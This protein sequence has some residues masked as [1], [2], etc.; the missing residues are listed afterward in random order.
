MGVLLNIGAYVL[1][2]A[3]ERMTLSGQGNV[4]IPIGGITVSTSSFM[5]RIG[6]SLN[7]EQINEIGLRVTFIVRGEAIR[8]GFGF[9][10][11]TLSP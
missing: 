2:V 3:N 5:F 1:F 7:P 11:N 8:I 9:D 6:Y 4:E 10:W